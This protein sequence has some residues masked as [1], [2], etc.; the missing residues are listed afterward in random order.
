MKILVASSTYHPYYAGG[1]SYSAKSLAD[2]LS[3]CTDLCVEVLSLADRDS[4]D[5]VDNVVVHRIR[6]RNLYWSY[7]AKDQPVRRKLMWHLIETSNFRMRR[8]ARWIHQELRPDLVHFRNIEDFSPVMFY[9]LHD[10]GIKTL[11]TLNSYTMLEP[12]GTLYR[13]SL[14]DRLGMRL[15]E[16][17]FVAKRFYSRYVTAVAAVSQSTLCEHTAR[18]YYRGVP[19]YVVRT[20]MPLQQGLGP[21]VDVSTPLR[22]GCL[23]SFLETKGIKELI[24]A[25][26]QADMP[27]QRLI[28][29]GDDQNDY[30]RACRMAAAGDRRIEFR[31]HTQPSDFFPDIH[32]LVIPSLWKEPYP[33][34]LAEA[35]SYAL[36]VIASD[37]GGTKEGIRQGETG[38]I[39][40]SQSELVA[41]LQQV[42]KDGDCLTKMREAIIAQQSSLETDE[43]TEY[44]RI[45]RELLRR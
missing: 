35:M 2:G 19:N 42:G 10:L 9:Y 5:V 7:R 32:L 39:F 28:L 1:G 12:K 30:G 21:A 33:R 11:Q 14:K 24:L 18:G 20:V 37:R 25:F 31:G 6:P 13:S 34:V 38:F 45:Y 23:G 44:A 26:R 16:Y 17:A 41:L 29:G 8:I 27:N 15:A 3:R 40:R 43:S 22:I 36:P 4:R